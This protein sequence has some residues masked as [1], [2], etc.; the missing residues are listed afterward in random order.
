MP[1]QPFRECHLRV[2]RSLYASQGMSNTHEVQATAEEEG[3]QQLLGI[4]IGI[5]DHPPSSN[6]CSGTNEHGEDTTEDNSMIIKE[7][8]TIQGET[9]NVPD[10]KKAAEHDINHSEIPVDNEIWSHIERFLQLRTQ[11]RPHKERQLHWSKIYAES[12][13]RLQSILSAT[14]SISKQEDG[15]THVPMTTSR[16]SLTPRTPLFATYGRSGSLTPSLSLTPVS[17]NRN[18]STKSRVNKYGNRGG[19]SGGGELVTTL[20]AWNFINQML[21]RRSRQS[22]QSCTSFRSQPFLTILQKEAEMRCESLRRIIQ[23]RNKI[24]QQQH[25]Q[26]QLANS[27]GLVLQIRAGKR[28]KLERTTELPPENGASSSLGHTLLSKYSNSGLQTECDASVNA[29]AD[30]DFL[31]CAQMKVQLWASLLSSVREI[32]IVDER[33]SSHV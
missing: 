14:S 26:E 13:S 6:Y 32:I 18:K 16:S 23:C 1:S 15:H 8:I 7:I 3:Q 20:P 27:E 5:G 28:R 17:S 31:T 21:Y 11:Y 24:N 12:N 30:E 22:M 10:K 4:G 9:G 25:Q 33:G 2:L 29:D 19:G